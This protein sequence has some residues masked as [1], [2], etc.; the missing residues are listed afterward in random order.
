MAGRMT[1]L[2][3]RCAGEVCPPEKEMKGERKKRKQE[4][5]WVMA[6]TWAVARN[7]Q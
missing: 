3:E 6:K 4:R 5:I 1:A 2:I 7:D